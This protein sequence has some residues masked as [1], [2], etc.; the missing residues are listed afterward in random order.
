MNC[1]DCITRMKEVKKGLDEYGNIIEYYPRTE[2]R[3]QRI[4]ERRYYCKKCKKEWMYDTNLDALFDLSGE[5]WKGQKYHYN[6]K[7]NLLIPNK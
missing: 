2:G 7:R 5:E 1:P 3:E 4:T 6:A